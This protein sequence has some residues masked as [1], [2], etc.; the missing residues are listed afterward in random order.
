I[1][2]KLVTGVQTCALPISTRRSTATRRSAAT[3]RSTAAARAAT[4]A[5]APAAAILEAL[6]SAVRFYG[7]HRERAGQRLGGIAG[8]LARR[9]RSEERRVG[10]EGEAWWGR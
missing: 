5:A 8:G 6:A 9:S 10:R 2:A 3:W 4:A 1:R 7:V